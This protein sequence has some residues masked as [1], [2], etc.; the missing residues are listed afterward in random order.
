MQPESPSSHA[1]W[2]LVDL[3]P[4]GPDASW[5]VRL[6]D[7]TRQVALQRDMRGFHE[8]VSHKLLTP[9]LGM[10]VGLETVAR[11]ADKLPSDEVTKIATT[12]LSNV[13]R[14][15]GQIQDILQYL[16][17]RSLNQAEASFKLELLQLVATNIAAELELKKVAVSYQKGLE[18][19][20]ISLSRQAVE[21]ILREILENAKKFHPAQSPT[22][23]INLAWSGANQ[24]G[25]TIADDGLTLS[26][27]QLAQV[28]TPYYQ[29]E[30]YF[31][32]EV[33]GMGLGLPI[34]A[35]LV[36]E[37]GGAGRLYNREDGP[38]LAVELILPLAG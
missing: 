35:S 4:A 22:V 7:V 36:W 30:K 10:Q 11:H 12:A 6:R 15:Q 38:G 33:T 18:E 14:L 2:L 23:T 28:W 17:A 9:I 3:F 5:V 32:G 13:K 21:L 26:P 29:G 16:T 19:A 27:E 34:V 20:Q 25:L 8:M 1:F 37:A 24:V 31:T